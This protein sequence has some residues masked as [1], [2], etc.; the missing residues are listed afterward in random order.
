MTKKS[1]SILIILQIIIAM[2]IIISCGQDKKYESAK[3]KELLTEIIKS[4]INNPNRIEIVLKDL[5]DF[6]W[7]SFIVV[8]P[9]SKLSDL[10]K[11]LKINLKMI[12]CTD[13]E[14]RDDIN[15]LVFV[16][17]G[18]VIKF[19]EYPRWPGDFIKLGKKKLYTPN[20]A[21]F[22]VEETD[23]NTIGGKKLILK[24]ILK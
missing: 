12:E 15:I 17:K 23:V 24:D 9:Y 14:R 20:D 6:K 13:I 19:I 18:Q 2:V 22:L 3:F 10:E 21:I 7:D 5:T 1:K 16:Q 8:P 11:E 4:K